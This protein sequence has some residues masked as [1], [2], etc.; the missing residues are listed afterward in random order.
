MFIVYMLGVLAFFI[1]ASF[2]LAVTRA[3]AQAEIQARGFANVGLVTHKIA[4]GS[5]TWGDKLSVIIATAL[6]AFVSPLWLL[7]SVFIGGILYAILHMWLG[8]R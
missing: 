5:A 3:G 7:S 4:D 8:W 1:I 2:L 6:G